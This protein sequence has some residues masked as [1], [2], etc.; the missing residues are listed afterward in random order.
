VAVAAIV[1]AACGG[2]SPASV[3]PSDATA[4]VDELRDMEQARTAL[5]VAGD[6]EAARDYLAADFELIDPTGDVATA[7]G[8][9]ELVGSG[10]LDYER[11]EPESDV[12][13]RQVGDVAAMRYQAAIDVVL[14]GRTIPGTF[15]LTY[16]LERQGGEWRY[17]WEQATP[18]L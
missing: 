11:W 12:Q 7:D 15:W 18:V 5:L 1:T 14:D 17:V 9:L 2:S 16:L 3:P 10:R 8:Y 13:I 4:T 6:A